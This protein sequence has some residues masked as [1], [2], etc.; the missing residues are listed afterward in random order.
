MNGSS[1]IAAKLR[2]GPCSLLLAAPD[3]RTRRRGREAADVR[4]LL[5]GRP[6]HVRAHEVHALLDDLVQG[7]PEN[8]RIDVVLVLPDADLFRI[9]LDQLR[10]GIHE[11]ARQRYRAT[12]RHRQGRELRTA[13][14]AAGVGAHAHLGDDDGDRRVLAQLLE[15]LG[16][17]AFA[18][19]PA[20]SVADGDELDPVRPDQLQDPLAG[21]GDLGLVPVEDLQLAVLE[22]RPALV[23]AGDGNGATQRGVHPHDAVRPGGRIEQQVRQ[24]APEDTDRLV[25]RAELRGVQCILEDG[26]PHD[27]DRV[28]GGLVEER[29][30]RLGG[31]LRVEAPRRHRHDFLVV[32]GHADGDRTLLLRAPQRQEAV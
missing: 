17:E 32:E 19:A 6:V 9:H 4:E 24:V 22:M 15:A 18:L 11:A 1:F 31:L 16:E 3:Q 13:D 26:R 8:R 30:D 29:L 7:A 25:V 14:R 21:R 27:A 23:D 5:D 2:S 28:R 20:R 10:Q 12:D